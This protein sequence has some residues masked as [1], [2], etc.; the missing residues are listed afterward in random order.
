ML[1]R[2]SER[3]GGPGGMPHD[4]TS[5]PQALKWQ[6][7]T[8]GICPR[9]IVIPRYMTILLYRGRPMMILLYRGINNSVFC[10]TAL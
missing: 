2:F 9:L 7:A 6:L 1:A 8:C 4:M 10:H 3:L 5:F